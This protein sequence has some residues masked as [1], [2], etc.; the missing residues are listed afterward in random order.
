MEERAQRDPA[1]G[2]KLP[3]SMVRL[4]MAESADQAHLLPPLPPFCPSNGDHEFRDPSL[5]LRSGLDP[6][7]VSFLDGLGLPAVHPLC[8]DPIA[9][10]SGATDSLPNA[11]GSE[12]AGIQGAG[13]Y[14]LYCQVVPVLLALS[15]LW[16]RLFA[17]VLAPL[18]VVCL[19]LD[20]WRHAR[21]ASVRYTIRIRKE[22]PSRLAAV[23]S[24]F[25]LASAAVLLTDSLYVHHFGRAP[26]A[27]LYLALSA[28]SKRAWSRRRFGWIALVLNFVIHGLAAICLVRSGAGESLADPPGIDLPT[29]REGLY[30]SQ[31]NRRV[32]SIVER[33]P[34]QYRSYSARAGATPW[35]L[36]GDSR[37]GIPFLVNGS[38]SIDYRR[39]WVRNPEDGEHVALDIAFPA[40]HIHRSD[41]PVYLIL[42]GLSGGSKED[43]IREFVFRRTS[44]GS[45]CVV[46]VARGLMTTPVIGWNL[47]H[48]AR[49]S[50]VHAAAGVVRLGLAP[51]QTLAGA[52]YSMGAIVL[53][54]Y[55]ARSS[56]R[57]RL[58]AAVVVSGGL[59]MREQI[60]FYRSQRLWQP[61]LARGLKD[62][63]LLG[64]KDIEAKYR[65]RLSE[66]QFLDLARSTSV[67]AIDQHGVV[68]YNNYDD[69]THYYSDM[70]ANGDHSVCPSNLGSRDKCATDVNGEGHRTFNGRV[71]NI[72]IPTVAVF[73]L[74]DPLITWRAVA[75]DDPQAT[76]N[77]GSGN[78]I[79]LLT[80]GGGHVGWPLG[81]SPSEMKRR[82][83]EWMNN[84]VRDFV[85][86]VDSVRK[87]ER[88]GVP[89]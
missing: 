62:A 13:F 77:S 56:E 23:A 50:D 7:A 57:C 26:G 86:S 47:F 17:F 32:S 76:A 19:L 60:N 80:N 39:V 89:M 35:L 43:Y 11:I 51:G 49:V 25:G 59:D 4:S 3:P 34:E 55:V 53:A 69:L 67:T 82:G 38:P 1:I 58:D 87:E 18:A 15:E 22:S 9:S 30:Y 45:T 52:G 63:F 61:M 31:E 24:V 75:K 84:A 73:A 21:S 85:N 88:S 78:L 6:S 2:L 29:A 44:E 14:T 20:E 12:G 70:S 28:L 68:T 74:D 27:S 36:T 71:A 41:K 5:L 8:L 48:G 16:L 54:N 46:M 66:A 81:T 40:D 10:V 64:K 33:W 79:L 72:T 83:W 42:H 37:T 65:H